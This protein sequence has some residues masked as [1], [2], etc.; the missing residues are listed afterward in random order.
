[1]ATITAHH[2]ESVWRHILLNDISNLAV[3][4]TRTH[5]LDGLGQGF[6]C[7]PHQFLVLLGDFANE[8]RLVEIPMVA[9]MKDGDIYVTDIA[10]LQRTLVGYAVADDLIDAGAARLGEVVVVQWRWVTVAFDGRLVHNAIQLIRCYAHFN[11]F[12][13]FVQAFASQSTGNT[14]CLDFVIIEYLDLG[15]TQRFLRQRS[16]RRVVGIIR[17]CNGIRHSPFGG[18]WKR[19]QFASVTKM[20]P[21]IV[22][23]IVTNGALFSTS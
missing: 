4:H 8:E 13:A 16:A 18:L 5:N 20:W 15:P 7:D 19:T 2:T 9:A 14:H 23:T 11:G 22:D 10:I 6:M 1:M 12:G 17:S 21:R 3:T